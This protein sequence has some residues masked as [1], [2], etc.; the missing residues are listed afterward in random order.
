MPQGNISVTTAKYE[1]QEMRVWDVAPELLCRQHLLGEHRELHAIHSILRHNKAGYRQHPETLR[2]IGRLDALKVRHDL[3]VAEMLRR[4][5][6]HH[7]PLPLLG[8][9]TTQELFVNT[10]QEQYAIL[11]AKACQ[12]NIH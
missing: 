11:A 4:G 9:G 3:L 1:A 12:C 5:W 7:T 6:Q 10:L 2:W 8:D